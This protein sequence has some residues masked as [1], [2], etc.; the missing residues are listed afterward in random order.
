M[1]EEIRGLRAAGVSGE[2]AKTENGWEGVQ[3]AFEEIYLPKHKTEA[4]GDFGLVARG[5]YGLQLMPWC[6]TRTRT[7]ALAL[8]LT[9]TLTLPKPRPSP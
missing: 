6:V 1:E 7:L 9:L 4:H 3:A 5:L 8:T 2:G